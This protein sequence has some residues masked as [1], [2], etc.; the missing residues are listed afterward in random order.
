MFHSKIYFN[1]PVYTME[2]VEMAREELSQTTNF[3]L[4]LPAFQN[5]DLRVRFTLKIYNEDLGD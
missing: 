4:F 5:N 1:A 3:L 2:D